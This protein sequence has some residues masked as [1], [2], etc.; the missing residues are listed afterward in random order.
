MSD[1]TETRVSG[2]FTPLRFGILLGLFV[3]TS[4]PQVILGLQTFVARDFGFFAYP[5][6]HF[7]RDCFWHGQIPFWDPYN[8]C[9]I[10]F[11]AQWNTMPLYPPALIY[12]LLPLPWSLSLFSLL[13]LWFGGM[14]MF[15]LARRWTGNSLAAAFAG[16]V[17]AFNGMTLN[18]LVWPSHVATFGWMPWV[19]LAVE[20]AWR[21]G[22]RKLFL[23][24][25]AGAMQ[26]LAGGPEIIFFTWILL[27]LLWLRHFVKGDTPRVATLWRFPVV[28]LLV[29]ALAAAQ[30]LPFLDLAAH[31]ERATGYADLRWS[32]PAWG[33]VN[34]I[35]PMAFGSSRAEGIFFQQGQYWTSSYYLG[36]GALWLALFAVWRVRRPR[37]LLLAA[38]AVVALIFALGG[39]T[40]VYPA[41]RKVIPELSLVTYPVKY[42]LLPTFL[43]PLLA[44]FALAQLQ[45]KPTAGKR[46]FF[47]GALLLALLAGILFWAARYPLH[48]G[49]VHA[50]LMNGLSRA[51]FLVFTGVVLFF[52]TRKPEFKL[53]IIAP[54][55]LLVVA[56]LDV[57]THEPP[58][59]PTVAP[60]VYQPNLA[61]EKLAMNP[62]P[63]LGQSRA[64]VSPMAF[65]QLI[66]FALPD[67]KNNYLAKRLGYC[68]NCNLLD[69][70]PKV[71]GFFSLTPRE[72]NS[73]FSL[74]YG[75][76]NANFS[77]LENFMGVSQI[78]A[79]D[80]M[81]HWQP[82][83]TFFPLVTAGQ[84]P[85]F[86]DDTKDM[87]PIFGPDFDGQKVAFFDKP[88]KPGIAVTNQTDA[89]VLDSHFGTQT[90]T[91]TIEASETSIVVFSQTYYHDWR[92]YV[93]G[94]PTPL[95]RADYAFQAV[96]V[97]GGR[98]EIQ[99]RYQD[100]AFD[101][102]AFFSVGGW[103][104]CLLTLFVPARSRR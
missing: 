81:F 20:A 40:F 87:P 54:L 46:L 85:M 99:L 92:A 71:D 83:S 39:N 2:W 102:G 66:N 14:G 31:S 8:D 72:Y 61:R 50:T 35:V 79:S 24:A 4:F 77:G 36:I 74:L 95:L 93:D 69:G 101:I 62:Q 58:Q 84:K 60:N 30:L 65:M 42:A 100:T 15:F 44:A 7:Q 13:H 89:R 90:V 59:N 48:E 96:Q 56:W 45:E 86:S 1:K 47:P 17:F 78:T 97:P 91:A 38:V 10:P 103:L 52:L 49:N 63:E 11:L 29:T 88:L 68:A 25:M 9:G 70:V 82:R 18:L 75:A 76:T 67:P 64:M 27:T 6:A 16:T 21:D 26:M 37:V 73:V 43:A 53:S 33:W 80:Q 23:A 19:V 32:M 51:A 94:K 28:V 34:Y 22:G 104:I 3:F 12:L 57:W 5:L 98:H 41:V 55:L